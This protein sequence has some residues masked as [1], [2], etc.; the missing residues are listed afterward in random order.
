MSH[1]G[2]G[3]ATLGG[4]S[5]LG[6]SGKGSKGP[7]DHFQAASSW[8]GLEGGGLCP[9]PTHRASLVLTPGPPVPTISGMLQLQMPCLAVAE[10]SPFHLSS[11]QPPR[12][13]A[14][15]ILVRV[16]TGACFRPRVGPGLKGICYCCCSQGQ[17]WL[18]LVTGSHWQWPPTGGFLVV[19]STDLSSGC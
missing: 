5:G 2:L 17:A 19:R 15:D 8:S 16:G 3:S 10:P 12:D 7:G 9:Y 11:T 13:S 14:W 6:G 1:T 18:M 4:L